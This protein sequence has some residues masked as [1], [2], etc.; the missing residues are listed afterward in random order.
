MPFAQASKHM[1]YG[2]MQRETHEGIRVSTTYESVKRHDTSLAQTGVANLHVQ[3]PQFRI[4]NAIS[5]VRIAGILF[6]NI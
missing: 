4:S 3:F 2:V 5:L 1:A 6:L